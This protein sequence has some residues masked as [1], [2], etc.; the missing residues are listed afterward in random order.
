[1]NTEIIKLINISR[2]YKMG[3][4]TIKAINDITLSINKN[5]Y[6]AIM[7]TSG[8]GKST[9]MNVLG[10]LD[11]ATSG[12]YWLNNQNVSKMTDENLA[13]IR[14][15]EI[16]FVFQTF[17]LLPRYSALDN[18]ILPLVYAGIRKESRIKAGKKILEEVGLADRITH[19][20]NEL[21]GGECQRVAIGRAL[22]NNPLIILADEPTGNLDSKIS[23]EIMSLFQQIHQDGN[24]VIVVTHE[25]NIARFAHRIIKLKDGEVESDAANTNIVTA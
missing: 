9:L 17:N 23:L 7:G 24:T 19:R 1:M 12:K 20:P 3:A 5:E 15:K 10:C 22:I 4:E 16:G 21:S 14:N 13:E 25:E 11:S 18:V 2:H 6:V 8:S